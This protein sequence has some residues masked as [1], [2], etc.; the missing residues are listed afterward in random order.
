MTQPTTQSLKAAEGVA[1]AYLDAEDFSVNSIAAIID[2][3]TSLPSLMAQRDALME[4]L[5]TAINTVEC[6][7]IDPQTGEELPW[8]R[9]AKAAL[10]KIGFQ[11]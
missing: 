3:S 1:T 4:A 10:D 2:S 6:A 9:Q 5:Q 11:P 8:Y 7:S